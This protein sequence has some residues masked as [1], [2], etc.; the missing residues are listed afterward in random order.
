MRLTSDVNDETGNF[1]SKSSMVYFSKNMFFPG[2][3]MSPPKLNQQWLHFLTTI[4]WF[5]IMLVDSKSRMNRVLKE[6]IHYT[7]RWVA[8]FQLIH[9]QLDSSMNKYQK[10]RHTLASAITDVKQK[11]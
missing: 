7:S 9:D 1:D 5:K 10:W 8:L 3:Y 2:T 4:I 11:K 6:Y